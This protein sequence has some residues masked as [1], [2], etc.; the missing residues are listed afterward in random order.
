MG[1]ADFW[2]PRDPN[3]ICDECGFKYKQSELR[4]RWDGLMVC[5]QD[6]EPRQPQ[7]FVRG[8]QD[9]KPLPFTRPEA[10]DTFINPGDVTPGKLPKS[11]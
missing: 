6:W 11:F 10:P 4:R 7:D 5:K 2:K 1:H 3:A 9:Q 8:V